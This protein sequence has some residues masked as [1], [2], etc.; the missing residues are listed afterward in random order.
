[1]FGKVEVEGAVAA[2]AEDAT[3]D[4]RTSLQRR[5]DGLLEAE[6]RLLC[7]G[8]LPDCGGTPVTVVATM[9][10][11]DLQAQTGYATTGHGELFNV[12]EL[13]R[14]AA[15][16]EIIPVVLTDTGGVMCYG[17][18]RRTASRAQ[19]RAL[20]ARDMGAPPACG[21]G[22]SFPGCTR[23][24]GLVPGPPHPSLARGGRDRP[25]ESHPAVRSPPP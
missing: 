7:A 19:R 25:R 14:L 23:P 20:A 13:L 24:P 15:E 3:P 9:N 2:I 4:T 1:M 11:Q 10:G 17:R 6:L 8:T 5:H 22:C 12:A 16:A 21:G 18:A